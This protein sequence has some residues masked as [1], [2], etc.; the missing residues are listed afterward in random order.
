MGINVRLYFLRNYP[1]RTFFYSFRLKILHSE[2]GGSLSE[3]YNPT[4]DFTF[5]QKKQI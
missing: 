4:D 1:R 5:L 3:I 2:T